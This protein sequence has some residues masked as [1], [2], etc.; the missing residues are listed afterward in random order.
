VYYE[1]KCN[2]ARVKQVVEEAGFVDLPFAV[3]GK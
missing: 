1:N 2:A 3:T